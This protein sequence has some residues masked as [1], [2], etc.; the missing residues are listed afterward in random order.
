M[1]IL[2]VTAA[3]V[4]TFIVTG[5][6]TGSLGDLQAADASTRVRVLSSIAAG[7]QDMAIEDVIA[8]VRAGLQDSS[9]NGR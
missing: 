1:P 2:S 9:P 3:L 8:L 7:Q 4:L 5:Q 6:R